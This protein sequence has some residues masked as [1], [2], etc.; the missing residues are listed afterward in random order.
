MSEVIPAPP[1]PTLALTT[2]EQL[3]PWMPRDVEQRGILC[4]YV[5]EDLCW[6]PGMPPHFI[7]NAPLP[8]WPAAYLLPL[9]LTTERGTP[10][11]LIAHVLSATGQ[12]MMDFIR[13]SRNV[14]ELVDLYLRPVL[15]RVMA[16]LC[17]L[18]AVCR[19]WALG[20]APWFSVLYMRYAALLQLSHRG[21]YLKRA[22]LPPELCRRYLVLGLYQPSSR[23]DRIIQLDQPLGDAIVDWDAALRTMAE[24]PYLLARKWTNGR[25]HHLRR[26][27][28]RTLF[29]LVLV[30]NEAAE[31]EHA[32]GLPPGSGED[33]SLC[34]VIQFDG[35]ERV[36]PPLAGQ[37]ENWLRVVRQRVEQRRA[38]SEWHHAYARE[39]TAIIEA[40]PHRAKRAHWYNALRRHA[41][42]ER[43]RR[44][45]E[46]SSSSSSDSPPPPKRRRGAD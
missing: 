20:V 14:R 2:S 27:P 39:T 28:R 23:L 15:L 16:Q 21:L 35:Q 43:K 7:M 33:Y 11:P 30:E 37:R 45:D 32:R 18:S 8:G 44:R 6:L 42:Q 41:A 24:Y 5:L 46:E 4:P 25:G 9:S 19:R 36:P 40:A 3:W 38:L 17:R 12:G 13:M 29:D 34:R 31:V 1:P 22:A 26:G 10:A